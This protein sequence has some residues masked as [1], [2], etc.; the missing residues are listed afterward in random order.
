VR[1]FPARLFFRFAYFTHGPGGIGV[2]L[3][4]GAGGFGVSGTPKQ[5]MDIHHSR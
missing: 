5:S 4:I 2:T 3:A 1:P